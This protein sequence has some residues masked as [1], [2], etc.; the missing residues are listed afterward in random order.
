VA[1]DQELPR[2]GARLATTDGVWEIQEVMLLG[3]EPLHYAVRVLGPAG[4]G[5]AGSR[6]SLVLSRVE[7]EALQAKARELEAAKGGSRAGK[8][9][10]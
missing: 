8:P 6:L 7:Y 9:R 3:R 10:R 5:G 1:Q 4:P 2:R